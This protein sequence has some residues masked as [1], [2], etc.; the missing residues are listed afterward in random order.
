MKPGTMPVNTPSNIPLLSTPATFIASPNSTQVTSPMTFSSS[1]PFASVTKTSS[2]KPSVVPPSALSDTS[3]AVSS[4]HSSLSALQMKDVD[5]TDRDLDKKAVISAGEAAVTKRKQMRQ[6]SRTL[7]LEEE[8]EVQE[9]KMA[10]VSHYTELVKQ[11]SHPEFRQRSL[12]RDRDL[13]RYT[14]SPS[15]SRVASPVQSARSSVAK[16]RQPVV[17]AKVIESIP[18]FVPLTS[19]KIIEPIPPMIPTT[20]IQRAKAI[21]PENRSRRGSFS[22]KVNGLESGLLGARSSRRD[23]RNVSPDLRVPDNEPD[24][25][26]PPSRN[27]SPRPRSRNA[28]RDA[29]S[30]M[31]DSARAR[32]SSE[33]R[34]GRSP[35]GLKVSRPSSRASSA[36]RSRANTPSGMKKERLQRA[37][38]VDKAKMEENQ[39]TVRW[40][41]DFLIDLALLMGAVYVYFSKLEIWA[42]PF[43]VI[44]L[45]RQI[46]EELR[47]WLPARWRH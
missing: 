43:I 2:I 15:E 34:S 33:S 30:L 19:G 40:L 23:S 16:E 22:N 11:Y 28:S 37:S 29:D 18:P 9:E 42:I 45:F 8:Q 3:Q 36:D 12:S 1:S 47:G 5:N 4:D 39:R 20:P 13:R 46:Q 32:R 41:R 31:V 26:R 35:T 38:T 7:S 14:E 17:P 21:N 10:V 6:G 24:S 25:G 44:L 27:E